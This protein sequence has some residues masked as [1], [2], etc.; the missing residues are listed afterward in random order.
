MSSKMRMN[1]SNGVLPKLRLF[2]Q[3]VMLLLI[4][5][6][7]WAGWDVEKYCPLGGML[8][9]GSKLYQGTMA[10]NLTAG[11][12][13]MAIALAVGALAV[14][15]LFCSYLCPIGFVSEWLGKLGRKLKLHFMM[16][17]LLDRL[18]RLGKYL[19]LFW[20]LWFTITR[21]ELFCRTFDPYYALATGFGADSILKWAL[22]SVLAFGLGSILIRQF[23]CKY[24]CP[25][26]AA[27]NL[28]AQVYVVLGI[29]GT[30]FILP[31][32]G[33]RL[34]LIAL[35][36]SLVMAGLIWELG[37]YRYFHFPL[38]KIT[39]DEQVCTQCLACTQACPHGIEVHTYQKVDHPDCMLCSECLHA[40]NAARA[41]TLNRTPG[42]AWLPPLLVIVLVSLGLLAASHFEFKTLSLRWGKFEQ[43]TPA[44]TYQQAGLKHVKCY[45]SAM[46]LY[47]KLKTQPG[48]YG[49]DAYA[50]AHRVTIYYDP[51]EITPQ[52]V[53][54]TLFTPTRYPLRRVDANTP[55][56]LAIWAV[57]VNRLFDGIDT[58]NFNYLLSRNFG[59]YGFETS[60]GEP[61]QT[62]IFFDPNETTSK[63]LLNLINHTKAIR[64]PDETEAVID[65]ECADGGRELGKI[66]R[67]HFQQRI[68]NG[69]SQE[70]NGYEKY[71]PAQLRLYEIGLPAVDN[72]NY[73]DEL[74]LLVAY[75]AEDSAL[76]GFKTTFTERAVALIYYDPARIDTTAIFTRLATDSLYYL[77]DAQIRRSLVNPFTP[78]YPSRSIRAVD[79]ADPS[80]AIRAKNWIEEAK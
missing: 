22:L 21:S 17:L 18:L 19:L 52:A 77:D 37:I 43:L 65:F 15:K 3:S 75:L 16:P 51:A 33:V 59:V 54:Q 30:W 50:S 11:A 27:S 14:G 58:W 64:W 1:W 42:L 55:D 32:L 10:C 61:V 20:V 2:M 24:L 35:L 62:V 44:A 60:F 5:W 47:Q 29:F 6:V 79:F 56:S 36:G 13:F 73:R 31:A 28:L 53:R 57:G 72:R 45:G 26:G 68:F 4:G 80:T 25:L 34:P 71:S 8:T 49:L 46:A 9:L 7:I 63:N 48:I 39:V 12:I 67:L 74:Q 38:T 40:C 69:F 41:I 78:E 76:V 66:S 70:F 23:W